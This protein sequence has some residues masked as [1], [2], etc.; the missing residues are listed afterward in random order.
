MFKR[1]VDFVEIKIKQHRDSLDPSS[2]RDYIDCFLTEMG[3]RDDKDSSFDI[4]NLCSC[5]LYLFAAG[6]ETTTTTLH[7][8][9]LYMIYYPQI[10]E[11]VQAEID[12]VIDSSR[13][14][15]LNDKEDMPYTNAVVHEIQRMA[16]IIPLNV[17][18]MATKDTTL[19]KYTIPKGTIIMPTL[20]SVLRDETMWETPHSFNPQ[21]FL[22]RDGQFRKREAFLSQQVADGEQPSLDFVLGFTRSPKPY[23]FC[24]V[25]R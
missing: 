21:H 19:D 5:T 13:V 24:A 15:S 9:L 7:W 17:A 6:T 4:E 11:R 18:R 22:D 14:P 25:P 10:Q 3:E 23:H 16:N 2:P 20:N 1:I 12:A 8:G